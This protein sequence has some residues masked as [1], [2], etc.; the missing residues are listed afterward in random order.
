M[1]SFGLISAAHHS[2]KASVLPWCCLLQSTKP[3]SNSSFSTRGFQSRLRKFSCNCISIF[4]ADLKDNFVMPYVHLVPTRVLVTQI[5]VSPSR[6]MLSFPA[7]TDDANSSIMFSSFINVLPSKTVLEVTTTT[8]VR[9]S[10]GD[11]YMSEGSH[12][13]MEA[14]K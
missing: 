4:H 12:T 10:S 1:D 3:A 13:G 2:V 11:D 6:S 9:F 7:M 8:V 5:F 14:A